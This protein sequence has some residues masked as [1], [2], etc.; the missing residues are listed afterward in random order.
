MDANRM[1]TANNKKKKEYLPGDD[2]DIN[3]ILECTPNS[4]NK[5]LFYTYYLIER[6]LTIEEAVRAKCFHSMFIEKKEK[7]PFNCPLK[8]LKKK[9]RIRRGKVREY[10]PYE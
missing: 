7:C 1:L 9:L 10:H 5:N 2:F 3:E 6:E 4:D 8:P